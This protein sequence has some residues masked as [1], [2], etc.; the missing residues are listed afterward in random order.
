MK[1]VIFL[2]LISLFL[3]LPSFAMADV[4]I[5]GPISSDT[6]WSPP[7]VYVI[8]SSFSVLAGITLTIEP[9][10]IIKAKST[11]YGGPSIYGR[12]IAHGTSELPIHFTSW[13]DD[14]I[15]GDTNGDGSGAGIPGS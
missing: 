9:D 7:N 2:I 14:S 13:G 15:G 6:T 4:V 8:D 12:L 10:T 5:S 1:R 11:W 3:F